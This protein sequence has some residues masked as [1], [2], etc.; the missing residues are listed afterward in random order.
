MIQEEAALHNLQDSI[1]KEQPHLGTEYPLVDAPISFLLLMYGE[2]LRLYLNYVSP[3]INCISP[4]FC[5]S[6]G[7][8]MDRAFRVV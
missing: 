2:S 5:G 4:F 7:A 3:I 6:Y 8:D 1:P